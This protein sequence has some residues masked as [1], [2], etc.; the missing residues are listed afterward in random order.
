[1]NYLDKRFLGANILLAAAAAATLVWISFEASE[2]AR[3]VAA[4]LRAATA[5]AKADR[6]L[7]D[8]ME[9]TLEAETRQRLYLLTRN[10]KYFRDLTGDRDKALA[11]ID[12]Y[13]DLRA[14]L[15]DPSPSVDA[16]LRRQVEAEFAELTKT[17]TLARAGRIDDVLAMVQG[18]P[19]AEPAQELR[20][21]VTK[22]REKLAAI[23]LR[24]RQELRATAKELRQTAREG[25]VDLLM[26]S[27]VA[28]ATITY[29]T[30]QLVRAR[31]D[32]REA[33][34]QLESRVRER[35]RQ[36]ARSNEE[37]QRYAYIV[38]HDLRA[39]LVNIVGF[40][41]ELERAVEVLKAYV[42]ATR[43]GSPFEPMQD[44]Y[45]AVDE[46]GPEALRFIHA[47]LARMDAL[48][49][50]ILKLARQG[51]ASLQ[52]EPIA[53]RELVEDCV[54]QIQ[55]RLSESGG[56]ASLLPPLPDIVSDAVAVKQIFTNLLENAVKYL[57]PDRPAKITVSG[58]ARGALAYFEVR[59][60]GRGVA[61]RDQER[62]FDLFR[63]AGPQD[64]PGEGVGLAHVRSL[65]R[66]LGGE[67]SVESDG[68]S[69][70]AFRFSLARTLDVTA[71]DNG[72]AEQ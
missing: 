12:A 30:R 19:S 71:I 13:R 36:L 28:I 1:M 68:A 29:R 9:T 66:R 58:A 61:P 27:I 63:R 15:G 62:I 18:E 60:N 64:Q 47:S 4:N 11:D 55:L 38:S 67:I 16:R 8:L 5:A 24:Y 22:A 31:H 26:V 45:A 2:H 34:L 23:R 59:D 42:D 65:V 14:A 25:A 57:A 51:R 41:R 40:T 21:A 3:T 39:P 35:T 69:G 52:P 43:A 72:T 56:E 48:I 50:A 53:M 10:E 17:M 7:S 54:S 46:D 6:V 70:S 44:V 32:L 37:I 20:A 33:N 49:G